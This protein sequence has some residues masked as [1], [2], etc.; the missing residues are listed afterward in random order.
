MPSLSPSQ[1][2]GEHPFL[3][4]E[5]LTPKKVTKK[6]RDIGM[7]KDLEDTLYQQAY[8]NSKKKWYE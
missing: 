8:P 7:S 2:G 1:F 4:E 6:R 3:E 5:D